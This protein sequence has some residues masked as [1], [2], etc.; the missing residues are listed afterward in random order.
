MKAPV[1]ISIGPQCSGKTTYLSALDGVFDISLDN[2]GSTY[3]TVDLNIV[4]DDVIQ[5]RG[6]DLRKYLDN[7]EIVWISLL[8]KNVSCCCNM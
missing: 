3:Q 2:V 4:F 1:Y 6:I 5:P 7:T 8:F